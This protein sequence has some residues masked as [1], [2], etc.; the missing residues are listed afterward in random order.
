[1]VQE[2]EPWRSMFAWLVSL[3]ISQQDARKYAD[4]LRA[5]GFDDM[6]SLH[7]VRAATGKTQGTMRIDMLLKKPSTMYLYHNQRWIVSCERLFKTGTNLDQVHVQCVIRAA[8][9]LPSDAFAPIAPKIAVY[10]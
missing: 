4:A 10:S 3:R 6:Q 7:E 5:F 1:M 2:D 8:S 9:V